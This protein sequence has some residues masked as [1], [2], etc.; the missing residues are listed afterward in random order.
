MKHLLKSITSC[1]LIII[2]LFSL[3]STVFAQNTNTSDKAN[4]E[5]N[6]VFDKS[7]LKEKAA[8]SSTKPLHSNKSIISYEYIYNLDG[9][10]DFIYVLF[11]GAGYAIYSSTT[12]ELLEYN[13]NGDPPFNNSCEKKYYAG[14][15]NYLYKNN[16]DFYYVDNNQKLILTKEEISSV[17]EQIRTTT[18]ENSNSK[19]SIN[20]SEYFA[21]QNSTGDSAG[22]NRSS[23]SDD[24]LIFASPSSG[25]LIPNYKYFLAAP[26]IGRNYKNETY[27]DGNNSGTCGPVAAQLL[28]GY[29]NFYNDRRIIEDKYLNGYSD[30]ENTVVLPERNPNYCTDP[31]LLTSYTTGTRSEITGENSFY[32]KLISEIMSPNSDTSSNQQVKNGITSVLTENLSSSDFIIEKTGTL[33]LPVNSSKIKSEIDSGRPVIINT[34][35]FLGHSDHFTVGYGYQDYTYPDG[36]GTYSGYIVHYGWQGENDTCVWINSS[37]CGAFISLKMNHDHDYAMVGRILNTD[38]IEYKCTVCGQRTDS[39]ITIEPRARYTERV[40]DISSGDFK[41]HYVTFKNSGNKLIQSFGTNDTVIEIYNDE[42][43]LLATDDDSGYLANSLINFSATANTP[44]IIRIYYYYPSMSGETKLSIS[45]IAYDDY[46]YSDYDDF[47]RYTNSGVTHMYRNVP[48]TVE[49][50]TFW[51]EAQGEYEFATGY[52]GDTRVDT[53]LYLIDPA[54]TEPSYF[55]DDSGGDSQ[56]FL[57]IEMLRKPYYIVIATYNI[58][59]NSTEVLYLDIDPA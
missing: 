50:I 47:V 12:L 23:G 51:P 36:S 22:E 24:E 57:S 53:C 7:T 39:A 37:W 33:V 40:V 6:D 26:K 55:N 21:L 25:V 14:P 20:P 56:A 3:V 27:G 34:L 31:M 10:E 18:I 11:E 52:N 2:L 49:V 38:R 46:R 32:L 13:L 1:F 4:N 41:E 8:A 15:T 45:P 44:Y 9:S 16:D 28:L 42:Y 29:N 59:L 17:S 48:N 54:S 19:M 5:S 58:T 35:K 30:S 43:S